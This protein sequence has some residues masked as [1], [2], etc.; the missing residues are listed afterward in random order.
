MTHEAHATVHVAATP[1]AVWRALTEPALVARYFFGTTLRTDWRVGSPIVYAGEWQGNAYEDRGTVL[2]VNAPRR[3]VTDY[4]SPSSGL[5]DEPANHQTVVYAIAPDS[6]EDGGGCTVTIDQDNNRDVEGA[7]H[8]SANWQAVLDGLADVAAGVDTVVA[9]FAVTGWE[10]TPL[11]GIEGEWLGAVVMRKTYTAGIRG[12]SVAS[13]VS[14]G[15]EE[16]GRG[17]LAAERIEGVFDDGRQGAFTVHHGALEHP[18][19]PSA[20]AWVVPGSGTGDL[21]E[22]RGSARIVHDDQGP[23]FV[24]D[25][26]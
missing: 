1:E 18:D 24:F 11:A 5:P 14:S 17:Y 26:A 23:F 22:L 20:F 19:D 12:S 4:F 6:A 15:D 25:F 7:A 8:A 9:R 2:E 13:F 3:L 10:P 16:H 21:A